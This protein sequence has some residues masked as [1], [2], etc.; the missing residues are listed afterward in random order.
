VL[1]P[2]NPY[3]FSKHI[4]EQSCALFKSHF[5][6]NVVTLRLANIYGPGQRKDFLVLH[7]IA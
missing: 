3:A 4:G 7:I 5:G 1:K 2:E 6:L